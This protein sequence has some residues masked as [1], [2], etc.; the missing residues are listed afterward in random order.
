MAQRSSNLRQL[1]A[2]SS[3]RV[4]EQIVSALRTRGYPDVRIAHSTVLANLDLGG[5]SVSAI[6]ARALVPKQ[7]VSKLVLELD[8][9]GYLSRE[10]HDLDRR[11]VIVRLTRKGT[12]LMHVT[13][14]VIAEFEGEIAAHLGPRRYRALCDTL[15]QIAD[16][17]PAEN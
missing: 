10:V 9:M 13:L 3:R 4:N 5:S 16:G 12:K 14:E 15:A 8:E 1:L 2:R 7:A 17:L 11:W 6:A